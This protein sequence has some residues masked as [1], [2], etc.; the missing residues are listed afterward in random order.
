MELNIIEAKKYLS[1]Q[2]CG[3]GTNYSTT[4]VAALLVDYAKRA[5]AKKIFKNG[6]CQPISKEPINR[7]D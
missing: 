4:I 6:E 5:L 2:G 1:E 3:S 7:L